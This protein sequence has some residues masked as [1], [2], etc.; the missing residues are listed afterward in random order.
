MKTFVI[1]WAGQLVSTLGSAITSFCLGVWVYE[2]TAY[3]TLFAT[4]MLAWVLPNLLL[5][6]VAGVSGP[7][8]VDRRLV[9]IFA[10]TGAA[11]ELALHNRDALH[12]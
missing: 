11:L 5:S 9:M 12:R 1:I 2:T 3:S 8:V 4:S 10:D 7:I 6:P